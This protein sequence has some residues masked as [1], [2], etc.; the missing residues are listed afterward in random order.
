M[1]EETVKERERQGYTAFVRAAREDSAL[2]SLV[3]ANY[4]DRDLDSAVDRFIESDE[5]RD[6]VN[7][8]KL[9]GEERVL[10]F[11]AGRGIAAFAFASLGCESVALDMN[12]SEECGVSAIP[13]SGRFASSRM[14]AVQGDCESMPF[15]D[16]VFDIV[17][18]RHVLHHA[19]NLRAM[20]QEAARVLKPGGTFMAW[21]EHTRPLLGRGSNFIEAHPAAAH[22]ANEQVFTAWEYRTACLTAGL[23]DVQLVYPLA[24]D[25]FA[26]HLQHSARKDGLRRLA[27]F[28]VRNRVSGPLARRCFHELWKMRMDYFNEAGREITFIARKPLDWHL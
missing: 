16:D 27:G 21:G 25:Q 11:G 17:Y 26:E 1:N 19:F 6:T 10:D 20:V 8:L 14:H 7:L 13:R 12:G 9:T 22:G 15:P 5:F 4:F 3:M 18:C 28:L 24:R 2:Q 23:R